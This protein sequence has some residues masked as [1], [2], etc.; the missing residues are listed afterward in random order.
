MDLITVCDQCLQ[1]SCWQGKFMCDKATNAGVVQ[2]TREELAKLNLEH[3]D[4]W[5]TDDELNETPL[6]GVAVYDEIKRLKKEIAALQVCKTCDGDGI[7]SVL[8]DVLPPD[9]TEVYD[10]VRCAECDGTG[11]GYF[12]RT[13]LDLKAAK[14]LLREVLGH[15]YSWQQT[16]D[17]KDRIE[18]FLQPNQRFVQPGP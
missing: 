15:V 17:L 2:K 3:P 8:A 11:I 12:A 10:D 1:A 9:E 18:S 4:N 5:K 13:T 6:T 16:G 7:M 14:D